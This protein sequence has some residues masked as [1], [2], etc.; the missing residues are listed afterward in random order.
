MS[1]ARRRPADGRGAFIVL[2]GLDGAGTTT[3]SQRLASALQGSGERILVTRQPSDGPLGTMLRQVLTGRLGLPGHKGPLT[4]DTL[5]LMFAA[6]RLDH[7]ASTIEPALE[8]GEVVVCDRYVLSSLAYQGSALPTAWIESLNERARRPDLT[9]F[10]EVDVKVAS[11]RRGA[12]GSNPELFEQD[13][14]QR[15][16]ARHYQSAVRRRTTRERIVRLD[17]SAS[18]EEVTQ[19]ALAAIGQAL[20]IG[21][22]ARRGRGK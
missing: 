6:D 7:L 16:V 8:R 9:L 18:V 21:P 3:Q 2:E 15:R 1:P 13:E 10:L 19:A 22:A 5:A 20:G 14:R 11:R 4:E 17:G 12:R